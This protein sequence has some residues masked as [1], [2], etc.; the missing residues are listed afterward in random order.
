MSTPIAFRVH[1]FQ[2]FRLRRRS[3][4]EPE[5]AAVV[6]AVA[7][8][9]LRQF[10]RPRAVLTDVRLVPRGA[11]AALF[12]FGFSDADPGGVDGYSGYA[13]SCMLCEKFSRCCRAG[14]SVTSYSSFVES[15][16]YVLRG[17]RSFSHCGVWV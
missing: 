4:A 11:A 13:R 9:A 12:A 7:M 17:V 14:S 2:S 6:I 10:V 8:H 15:D 16:E 1:F 5:S 3:A